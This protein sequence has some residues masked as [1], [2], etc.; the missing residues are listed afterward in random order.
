MDQISEWLA[1][2][3]PFFYG[4]VIAF[5]ALVTQVCSSPG[6]TFAISAFTPHLQDSLSLSSSQLAAA[7]MLGTM[8]AAIPL[9]IV[10]PLAD[11]FGLRWM[12]VAVG[13]ALSAS[14]F[15]ISQ[16]TGFYSLLMGFLLL[17]FLGQGSMT[18]LGG[19][20]VSMWFR[21]KLGTVNAVMS[22]GGA[23]AFAT[24]PGLMV[25]TIDEIGWRA[26]YVTLGVSV[27][28]LLVPASI[29]LLRNRPEDLAL[30][31]DGESP[32]SVESSVDRAVNESNENESSEEVNLT[33]RQAIAHRT[34]WILAFDMAAWALI[35]TGIV[36]HS[37]SIF[38]EQGIAAS[39]IPWMFTTFSMSMLAAQVIGGILADRSPMHW[40][41]AGGFALL[42]F[43]AAVVPVADKSWLMHLF[44][45]SFGAGQGLAIASNS[46]MWVRYYG[47]AHLGKIRGTVWCITVAASGCGP[48]ILGVFRD[49]DQSFTN[50][51]W[52]FAVTLVPL[53][54]ISL[55]AT[56]PMATGQELQLLKL[57][58]SKNPIADEEAGASCIRAS[59]T[60]KT[61]SE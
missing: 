60:N 49:S 36:F 33:L 48:F 28:V 27:F 58:P 4:Y 54:V 2:R 23:A 1:K 30:E 56:R 45:F 22:V 43:G 15:L 46:A 37:F 61:V 42:A 51:L 11:R 3:T 19:N 12:T 16:A 59:A 34:F 26:A 5:I 6:Q 14:C 35:G 52:L 47:R 29:L 13:L 55:W 40:L 38:S 10:G 17:R 20:L 41:L 57:D 31:I 25:T 50:G 24:V 9:A 32:G 53:A 21:K 7:Y 18:L 8:L 44:A 39:H